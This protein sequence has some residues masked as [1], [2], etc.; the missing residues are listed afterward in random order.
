MENKSSPKQNERELA[1]RS[2]FDRLLQQRK[3]MLEQEAKAPDAGVREDLDRLEHRLMELQAELGTYK[4]CPRCKGSFVHP[5]L[6]PGV[7]S[8]AG[9]Q[10]YWCKECNLSWRSDGKT[11]VD[12]IAEVKNCFA[13]ATEGQAFLRTVLEKNGSEPLSSEMQAVV[14]TALVANN[15]N[16]WMDGYKTGQLSALEHFAYRKTQDGKARTEQGSDDPEHRCPPGAAEQHG[17]DGLGRRGE[18]SPPGAAGRAH[19]LVAGVTVSYPRGMKIEDARWERIAL[20]IAECKD[21]VVSAA[22]KNNGVLVMDIMR[23]VMV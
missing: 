22:L 9:A 19:Q 2:E 10:A 13:G 18:S 16:V 23:E 11:L 21:R 17:E 6:G 20:Q 4:V 1:L 3:S 15:M 7:K 12:G 5:M 14:E 8:V